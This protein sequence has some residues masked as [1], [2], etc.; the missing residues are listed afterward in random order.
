MRNAEN[1]TALAMR[2]LE[3]RAEAQLAVLEQR[4]RRLG[5]QQRRTAGALEEEYRREHYGKSSDSWPPDRA[6]PTRSSPQPIGAAT[7]DRARDRGDDVS[8][9]LG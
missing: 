4:L 8:A 2:R 3:R 7:D 1:M 5:G 9:G 6:G